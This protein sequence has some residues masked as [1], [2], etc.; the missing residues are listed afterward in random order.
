MPWYILHQTLI[1]AFAAYLGKFSL[2]PVIKP[3]QLLLM[4]FT[5]C[6]TCD[7]VIESFT[8]TRFI[9]GLKLSRRKNTLN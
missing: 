5:D 1:I 3:L 6:F 9:F 7:E 4:P 8:L 2:G